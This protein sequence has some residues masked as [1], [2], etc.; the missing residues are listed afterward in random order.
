MS[1]AH[2]IVRGQGVVPGDAVVEHDGAALE[3]AAGGEGG[4]ARPA[5]FPQNSRVWDRNLLP[6]YNGLF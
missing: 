2:G 4:G 5:W 1:G 3:D 6:K